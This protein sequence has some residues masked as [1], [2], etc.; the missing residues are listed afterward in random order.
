[1]QVFAMMELRAGA[2]RDDLQLIIEE[3][4]RHLWGEVVADRVRSVWAMRGRVGGVALLEVSDVE[5]AK[6]VVEEM[7]AVRAG[8]VA[9]TL[10]PVAPF[11]GFE[12]LFRTH[13]ARP[14]TNW[15][16]PSN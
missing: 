14:V 11:R 1:M 4:E 2:S 15:E 3:E 5:E 10:M 6:R 13:H 12:V 7:P 9:F 16:T 8:L